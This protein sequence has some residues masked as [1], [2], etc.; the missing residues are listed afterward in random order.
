ME[1]GRLAHQG[2]DEAGPQETHLVDRQQRR[3]QP[4][5]SRR[6]DSNLPSSIQTPDLLAMVKQLMRE[7]QG[8]TNDDWGVSR[9]HTPFTDAILQAEYTRKFNMPTIPAYEGKTDPR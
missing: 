4:E 7:N 3:H 8:L 2:H 1:A 6:M 5:R 9:S